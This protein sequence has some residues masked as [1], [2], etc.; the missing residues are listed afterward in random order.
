M[1]SKHAR[2]CSWGLTQLINQHS[3]R[4]GMQLNYDCLPSQP[5]KIARNVQ[6][7]TLM[8][9]LEIKKKSECP[10]E[11]S[12][13]N[14]KHSFVR[15]YVCARVSMCVHT[16]VCLDLCMFECWN[17]GRVHR[18]QIFFLW[19]TFSS[20]DI[21]FALIYDWMLKHIQRKNF[22]KNLSLREHTLELTFFQNHITSK[23]TKLELQKNEKVQGILHSVNRILIIWHVVWSLIAIP[24][25][26]CK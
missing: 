16:C 6:T 21:Y 22:L 18:N 2:D 23:I 12:L 24:I 17:V 4:S 13:E 25:L 19:N 1:K 3:L 15:L 8:K 14:V 7:H 9:G 5:W 26:F 11:S 10:Y 20:I